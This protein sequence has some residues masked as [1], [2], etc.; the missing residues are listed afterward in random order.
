MDDP[1]INTADH[2][3]R[4]AIVVANALREQRI[5]I[6]RSGYPT[7]H[8]STE[9]TLE[10]IKAALVVHASLETCVFSALLG[11]AQIGIQGALVLENP[12]L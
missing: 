7:L 9:R 5:A 11:A 12:T 8:N 10:L 4:K 6:Y 1:G 3:Y 2:D